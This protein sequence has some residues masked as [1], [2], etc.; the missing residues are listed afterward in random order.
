MGMWEI[1]KGTRERRGRGYE[2]G[3]R[4]PPDRGF[5]QPATHGK[6]QF[7]HTSFAFVKSLFHYTP[8]LGCGVL[9][10]AGED[11]PKSLDRIAAGEIGRPRGQGPDVPR[12]IL[13][14]LTAVSSSVRHRRARRLLP[15]A[16]PLE[17]C[18]H[19]GVGSRVGCP[20][21]PR[22]CHLQA[23]RPWVRHSPSLLYSTDVTA[24]AASRGCKD[25]M[26]QYVRSAYNS[27]WHRF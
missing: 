22:P 2:R 10:P 24:E 8:G 6:T 27:A 18:G 17:P 21:G 12:R 1:V 3:L 23:M 25:W 7:L 13:A 11:V 5:C 26:N 15:T 4:G 20:Q 16:T 14:A 9:V 19:R